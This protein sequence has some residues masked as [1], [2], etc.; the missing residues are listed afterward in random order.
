MQCKCF[1]TEEIFKRELQIHFCDKSQLVWSWN[2][3]CKNWLRSLAT[4]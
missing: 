1:T 4:L 2:L 3:W